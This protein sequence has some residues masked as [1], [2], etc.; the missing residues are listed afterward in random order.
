MLSIIDGFKILGPMQ[1]VTKGGYGTT[2]TMLY[3]YNTA[4][5]NG[6]FGRACS[7]AFILFVIIIVF[8]ILQKTF[9]GKEVDSIE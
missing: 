8:T 1:L 4:F 3:I 2:S 9:S 7:F 5:E 6:R